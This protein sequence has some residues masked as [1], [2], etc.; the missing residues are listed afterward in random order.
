ATKRGPVTPSRHPDDREG[1]KLRSHR[2]PCRPQS[3]LRERQHDRGQAVQ[4]PRN[5]VPRTDHQ[6]CPAA[7]AP[8]ASQLDLMDAWR[9]VDRQ[10]SED[11][12]RPQAVAVNAPL[13]RRFSTSL[14]ADRASDWSSHLNTR[15][16]FRPKLAP[17]RKGKISIQSARQ[18]AKGPRFSTPCGPFAFL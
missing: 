4:H 1:P 9:L 18:S 8:I 7:Q 3:P 16:V 13:L 10:Y 12:P 15:N 5:Q 11:G 17:N 14:R 6:D 2:C